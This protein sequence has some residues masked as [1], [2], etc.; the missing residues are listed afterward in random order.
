LYQPGG[1][2][3]DD[4]TLTG[5]EDRQPLGAS[6]MPQ[7]VMAGASL[8]DTEVGQPN[9][10]INSDF[11]SSGM[12]LDLDL[13]APAESDTSMQAT[14]ALKV[15]AEPASTSLDMDFD[16]SAPPA[17]EA[18]PSAPAA[19]EMVAMDFDL[20]LPE[21]DEPVVSPPVAP[22]PAGMDFD[23]SSINLDLDLPEQAAPA[24]AP[25]GEE[26]PDLSTDLDLGES[27]DDEDGDPLARKIELAD[28]FRQIGDVEG[29]RDVLLEV[30][31]KA[32]GATRERAQ[33]MLKEIS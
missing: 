17:E 23:L 11:A 29:A 28:E 19:D 3:S 32:S 16:L 20:S 8:F 2:P 4:A 21:E 9:T 22:Q 30:I 24:A 10:Q 31:E 6:T 26:L 12:D 7:S 1:M 13:D 33:A 18:K 27:S 14:Q 15:T 25:V 5:Q